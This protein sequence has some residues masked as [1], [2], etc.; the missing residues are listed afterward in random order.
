MLGSFS[1]L[2]SLSMRMARPGLPPLGVN[3]SIALTVPEIVAWTGEEIFPS[4]RA[5]S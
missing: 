3:V 4:S 5:I 2:P 1:I